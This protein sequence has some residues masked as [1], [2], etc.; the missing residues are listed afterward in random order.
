[1]KILLVGGT[2]LIGSFL[3]NKLIE[4]GYSVNILSRRKSK[5]SQT[6]LWNNDEEYIDLAAFK[7]VSGI[8]NLT[9]ANIAEGRWTEKRKEIL[10]NSRIL[11]TRLLFETI[12]KNKVALDFFI[13]SSATG[14]Y[15]TKKSTKILKEDN[16]SGADFLAKICLD[17]ETEALRFNELNIRTIIVRTGIVLT[18]HKGAFEKIKIPIKFGI[19]PIFSNGKQVFSWIHIDDLIAVFMNSIT[20]KNYIGPYNAVAPINNTYLEFNRKIAEVLDKKVIAIK[21]PTF[22]LRLIFGELTET[23]TNGNQIAVE[24]LSN[25]GFN[26]KFKDL[27]SA[28]SNLLIN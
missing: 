1:L 27:N 25:N 19:L 12:K 3:K 18:R 9:G 2:G 20:N 15:G 26:F 4:E 11:S 10:Y 24:K 22:M 6:F 16:V 17:W 23:L 8:I 7:G 28:L 14:Y 5:D 13:N 21:I